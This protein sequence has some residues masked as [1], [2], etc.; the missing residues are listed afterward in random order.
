MEFTIRQMSP[1]DVDAITSTFAPWNKRREQYVRYFEEQQAGERVTLVAVSGGRVIGYT[2]V[3][4][5]S[6]YARFN[7]SGI[8]E[9]NDLNVTEGAQNRGVGRA[10]IREA[11][12]VVAGRGN[13]VV[14]IGVGLTPDYAAA[15]HLYPKL[16]YV[17][18]GRGIHHTQYGAVSYFTKRLGEE[19]SL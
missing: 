16:G 7:E 17:P 10:L 5:R 12:R 2:N 8:P 15:Q 14:G 13:R 4:W 1:D 11:E 19:A 18:D 9:I 3:L 6:G